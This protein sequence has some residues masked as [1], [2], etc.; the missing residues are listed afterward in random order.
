MLGLDAIFKMA[1]PQLKKSMEK[2]GIKSYILTFDEDGNFK[3]HAK[4]YC[5]EKM[6]QNL[7]KKLNP[8]KNEN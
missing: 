7:Y 1:A 8:E 6:I 2:E 3:V 4:K 5:A